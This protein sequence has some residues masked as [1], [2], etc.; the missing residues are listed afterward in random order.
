MK[1]RPRIFIGVTE[2]AGYFSNLFVGFKK[3]GIDASYLN[4]E[5]YKYQYNQYEKYNLT[6]FNWVIRLAHFYYKQTGIKASLMLCVYFPIKVITFCY[7]CFSFNVFIFGGSSTFFRFYDYRIL[8]F[9]GKKIIFVSLG[10]DSRPQF[11]NG[12]FKDDQKDNNLNIEKVV[13]INRLIAN[14]VQYVES[15]V[16][17][18]INYPQHAHFHKKP[19][20]SGMHVGFP[21]LMDKQIEPEKTSGRTKVRILH[22]PTRPKAKGSGYFSNIVNELKEEGLD[23]EYAVITGKSNK[24]VIL[25]ISKS[26]I[27]LDELY[28]D[29]AL[30]GLGAEAAALGKAVLVSGYYSSFINSDTEPFEVPPSVFCLPEQVKENLRLLIKNEDF[31]SKTGKQLYRFLSEQWSNISVAERYVKIINEQYPEKWLTHPED[32][33]YLYGW[34]LSKEEL[35]HIIESI[36]KVYGEDALCLEHNTTLKKRFLGLLTNRDA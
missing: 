27:I 11:M 25:E 22:A 17:I 8:R 7:A 14:K 23:F 2:M 13:T 31:R 6:F 35:G 19:F 1:G 9:L 10:S 12:N 3:M 20:I 15:L 24:E 32:L 28:S 30:G 5:S 16:D 26:D 36:V 29:M 33:S 18:C 34:G 21:S 4:L